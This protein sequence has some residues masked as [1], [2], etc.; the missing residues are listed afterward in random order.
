MDPFHQ[1]RDVRRRCDEAALCCFSSRDMRD[2]RLPGFGLR[3]L[4]F[5]VYGSLR[6]GM[7]PPRLFSTHLLSVGVRRFFEFKRSVRKRQFPPI[8]GPLF[9]SSCSLRFRGIYHRKDGFLRMYEPSCCGTFSQKAQ[10]PFIG[11]YT[12]DDTRILNMM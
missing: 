2:W 1:D 6:G 10:S 5:R 3:Y 4:G 9:V 11:E 7:V 8:V 12:L